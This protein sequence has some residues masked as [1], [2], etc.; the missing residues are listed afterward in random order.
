MKRVGR[1]L[2]LAEAPLGGSGRVQEG[3]INC[4]K[5]FGLLPEGRGLYEE[6]NPG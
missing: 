1:D 6:G 3:S 4:G 2:G 5:G